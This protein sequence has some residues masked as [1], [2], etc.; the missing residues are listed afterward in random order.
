[1]SPYTAALLA[2]VLALAGQS[3][4][5]GLALE[6]ALR[7]SRPTAWLALALGS[8]L[9]ALH[10]G[11]SLELALWA[12]IYDLRQAILAALAGALCGGAVLL[13][14]RERR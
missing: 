13:L 7:H 12:G 9:L 11:F 6:C 5:A 1:M 3:L 14:R 4:A 8:L 2:L 10:H